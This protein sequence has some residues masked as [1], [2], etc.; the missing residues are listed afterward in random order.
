MSTTNQAARILSAV[1]YF[2]EL[3]EALLETVARTAVRREY[4]ANET[5]F[6]EGDECA[7]LYI[8]ETGWL[9]SVKTSAE[10]REQVIRTVGPGEFFNELA[11]FADS[12]NVVTVI[13]LEP[14]VIWIVQCWTMHK[15]LDEQPRVARIV[16]QNLARRLLHLLDLVE[17]L[18]LRSVEARLARMLLAQASD[19][20]VQR[21]RWS[22][23]AEMA[24]ALGTVPDV[25]NRALRSLVEENLIEV[26]RREIRILDLKGLENRARVAG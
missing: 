12:K 5:V 25:L 23:Q 7:G 17:D 4:A 15:L 24:A 2:A 21:H 26:Q 18:S 19:G 11:I 22:T 1:P 16:A 10:G 3:D 13:A 6:V 20:I 8:V 14:A 9:K